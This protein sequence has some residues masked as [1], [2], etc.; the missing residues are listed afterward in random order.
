MMQMAPVL[1]TRYQHNASCIR[2]HLTASF[3]CPICLCS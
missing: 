2:R 1:T 3:P